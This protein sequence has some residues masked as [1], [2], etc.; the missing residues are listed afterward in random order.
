MRRRLVRSYDLHQHLW[1]EPFV[2]ALSRRAAPPRLRST[3]LETVEGEFDADLRAH[4]LGARVALL[5]RDRIDAAVVSLPPTLGV[6]LLHREEAAPLLE[7]YHDG[8]RELAASSRGRLV[9]LAAGACL[10]GFAGASIAAGALV[11]DT[12][13]L[14]PLLAELERRGHI[15]F[16]HP[17]PGR[18]RAGL[19]AW[20]PAV[21]DY[22]AQMQAAYAAWL[23]R[24]SERHPRLR[25]VF[26]ILAGGGPFQLERLRSRGVE[27]R[28]TLHA[29]VF[30]DTASYGRRAL[31]LCLATYGVRQ[32]VYGSDVPVIDSRPTL[33]ALREFGDAV[34]EA[35]CTE[36]ARLLLE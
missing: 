29:N 22:T 1:P 25:V 8:I 36:N 17:G 3:R 15:L 28:S 27:V 14:A 21:V 24:D 7:A 19:P 10:E 11:E 6:E 16:V 12:G 5:D 20:W 13:A 34:A 30:L 23:A 9:P 26:A 4:D 18:A 32:L 35:V 33:Q 31:E 2:S